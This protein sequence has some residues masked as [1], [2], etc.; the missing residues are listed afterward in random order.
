MRPVNKWERFLS[1]CID[2]C[3][4]HKL[5]QNQLEKHHEN[6]YGFNR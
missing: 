1:R 5:N 2:V 3:L 4:T 6:V